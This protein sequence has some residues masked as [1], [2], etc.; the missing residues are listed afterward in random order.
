LPEFLLSSRFPQA[1][2]QVRLSSSAASST[3]TSHSSSSNGISVHRL[4]PR[5]NAHE[6]TLHEAPTTSA[7]RLP[8]VMLPTCAL[9][10]RSD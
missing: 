3:F 9:R 4:L 8:S 7:H 10:S 1:P 2:P 6:F 5:L